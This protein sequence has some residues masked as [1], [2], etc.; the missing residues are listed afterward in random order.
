VELTRLA[1][2]RVKTDSMPRNIRT[3]YGGDQRHTG[4]WRAPPQKTRR[5]ASAA[6]FWA[7]QSRDRRTTRDRFAQGSRPSPRMVI[8]VEGQHRRE[9]QQQERRNRDEKEAG[10]LQTPAGG[11]RGARRVQRSGNWPV[12]RSRLANTVCPS[13]MPT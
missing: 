5:I 1:P 7:G 4:H 13:F 3:R 11:A 6:E 2:L 12:S 8:L 9:R 10:R